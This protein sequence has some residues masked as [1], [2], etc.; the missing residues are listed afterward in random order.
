MGE[1]VEVGGVVHTG[2]DRLDGHV[3]VRPVGPLSL[4][5]APLVG[6]SLLRLL[7]AGDA[8][9]LDLSGLRLGR[10]PTVG[11]FA[12]ALQAAGG[13]PAA[14]LVL[15][16]A[17]AL[18]E[19]ALR[20]RHV[21]ERVPLVSD[22]AAARVRVESPPDVVTRHFDLT[23][24][25]VAG[26]FARSAAQA[27]CHDWRVPHVASDARLIACEL[28][29]NAVEH[30]HSSPRMTVSLCRVDLTVSVRDDEIWCPT[31]RPQL[32]RV[33]EPGGW[34]LLMV[35]ALATQ[36]GV[37]T[38]DDGKTVWARLSTAAVPGGTR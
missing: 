24:S 1:V 6:R 26:S 18:M 32:R 37:T 8:V 31:V 7:V 3:V 2:V 15:F 11:V 19:E 4:S 25:P 9:L 20:A 22:H 27:A 34:G 33:G 38:H 36:W 23:D 12:M 16:G 21:P 30:A 14:R 29:M 10:A 35:T 28:V 17:D 5:T 13:W